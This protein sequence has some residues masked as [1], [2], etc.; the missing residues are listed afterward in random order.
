MKHQVEFQIKNPDR[1]L[2]DWL[3]PTRNKQSIKRDLIKHCGEKYYNL[4]IRNKIELIK[5]WGDLLKQV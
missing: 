4:S 2:M 5:F 3:L 1:R